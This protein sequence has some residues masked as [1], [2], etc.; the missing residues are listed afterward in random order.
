MPNS[1]NNKLHAAFTA[2]FIAAW[3]AYPI[4]RSSSGDLHG[5]TQIV[6]H[7]LGGEAWLAPHPLFHSFLIF[8][9]SVAP[10]LGLLAH[11][12]IISI[13][14]AAATGFLMYW[15]LR[16]N[17]PSQIKNHFVSILS[18][19]LLMLGP[20]SIFTWQE[21]YVGY[22]SPNSFHNPTMHALKPFVLLS[23]IFSLRF[24]RKVKPGVKDMYGAHLGAFFGLLAKPC[25][26]PF[27]AASLAILNFK[28]QRK[29]VVLTLI[30]VLILT[31]F[32]FYLT[33]FSGIDPSSTKIVFKP[34][35]VA[36]FYAQTPLTLGVRTLLSFALPLFWLSIRVKYSVKSP[37][38]KVCWLQVFF[39]LTLAFLFA[40]SGDRETESNLFWFA[41]ISL[42]SLMTISALEITNTL[43]KKIMSTPDKWALSLLFFLHLISGVIFFYTPY[44]ES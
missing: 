35:S 28:K 26:H 1:I 10:Q 13:A 43:F 7:F 41:E 3:Y 36:L 24:F 29:L 40:E 31:T 9:S 2:L 22:I 44:F 38:L 20:I 33:Y 17:L 14:C 37:L 25:F 30:P 19:T 18:L 39:S 6:N 8:S 34:F 27:F 15:L 42:F 4:I 12:I 16:E 11:G 23:L 32:Q 21:F 5:H